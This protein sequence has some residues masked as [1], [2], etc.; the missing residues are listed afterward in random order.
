MNS[1]KKHEM[2][3][4]MPQEL[5]DSFK[6]MYNVGHTG[7]F[8]NIANVVKYCIAG[9]LGYI[10]YTQYDINTTISI[11]S[12]ISAFSIV[13]RNK[14][15]SLIPGIIGAVKMTKG[16]MASKEN[17]EKLLYKMDNIQKGITKQIINDVNSNVGTNKD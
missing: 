2:F 10:A 12:G 3:R 5:F 15:I 1:M 17:A 11:L 6:Y 4:N 16:V 9:L 14:L 7:I 13:F 8:E